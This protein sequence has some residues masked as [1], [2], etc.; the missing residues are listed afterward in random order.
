MIK[1]LA[2]LISQPYIN[3]QPS[4]SLGDTRM[5]NKHTPHRSSR[6]IP[7][8]LLPIPEV[9]LDPRIRITF[10]DTLDDEFDE[11]VGV[12]CCVGGAVRC[13]GVRDDFCQCWGIKVVESGLHLRRVQPRNRDTGERSTHT[14]ILKPETQCDNHGQEDP[15]AGQGEPSGPEGRVRWF[16]VCAGNDPA[17]ACR[18]VDDH[19]AREGD[20]VEEDGV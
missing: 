6:I 15:E 9:S 13:Q 10:G 18:S 8:P 11:G 3:S 7:H 14:H 12:A 5:N 16:D 1:Y 17:S 20:A 2:R 4:Y 19:F